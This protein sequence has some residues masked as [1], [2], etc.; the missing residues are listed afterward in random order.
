[1]FVTLQVGTLSG[2]TAELL[3]PEEKRRNLPL[4]Y[5]GKFLSGGGPRRLC[6]SAATGQLGLIWQVNLENKH[7]YRVFESLWRAPG[8]PGKNKGLG[9]AVRYWLLHGGLLGR[10]ALLCERIDDGH[11]RGRPAQPPCGCRSDFLLL[12][13]FSC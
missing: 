5:E 12:P 3:C 1:M 13:L 11:G 2:I 8:S 7:I 6:I 9:V 10:K 4:V